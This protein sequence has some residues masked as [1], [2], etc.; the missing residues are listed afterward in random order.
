MVLVGA[1]FAYRVHHR[2]V[3]AKL[4]AVGVGKNGKLRDGVN[5]ERCAHD[6]RSRAMLPET[7]HI[8]AVE[9]IRLTL[10]AGARNGE[11][12][13][14]AVEQVGAAITD[15]RAARDTGNQGDEV[16]EIPAVERQIG[17][18]LGLDNGLQGGRLRIDLRH[19]RVDGYGLLGLPHH[20]G[21]IHYRLLADGQRDAAPHAG[22]E[23]L[24]GSLRFVIADGKFGNGVAALGVCGGLV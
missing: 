11:V 10:R 7:L 17:D 2:A 20:H 1:G 19:L 13:L 12:V 6:A 8:G 23:A 3:A 4:R 9:Q 22:L 5:A 24:G 15:L 14:Q 21:K 18:L 16:R